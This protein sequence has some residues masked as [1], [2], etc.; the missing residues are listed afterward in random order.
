LAANVLTLKSQSL[1]LVNG[2][3]KAISA[4]LGNKTVRDLVVD[5]KQQ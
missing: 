3:D 2:I 1:E 5:S 4:S